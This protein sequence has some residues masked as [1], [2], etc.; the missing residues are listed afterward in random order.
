MRKFTAVVLI[1]VLVCGLFGCAGKTPDQ[2]NGPDY[3]L[4][5]LLVYK[6]SE[7]ARQIGMQ[8]D[9]G[10]MTAMEF[11]EE[12]VSEAATFQQAVTAEPISA[13]VQTDVPKTIALDITNMCSRFAGITKLAC[14]GALTMSDQIY[15][16]HKLVTPA[17]VYLRYSESCQFVV[18]FTPLGNNLASVWAYPLYP[19]VT[20]EVL[21][22]YFINDKQLNAEQIRTACR[23]GAN[24]SFQAQCTDQKTSPKYYSQLATTVLKE[25]KPLE[26]SAVSDYTTD[27]K[28]ISNVVSLSHSMVSGI[29]SVQVFQFPAKLERQV[30]EI[31]SST[32]YSQQLEAY[33]RQLVYLT[34]PRQLSNRY[35]E[36]WMVTSSLLLATMETGSMGAI[37]T[38]DEVP[39]LVLIQLKGDSCLLMSVYPS[40][41]N[42]YLY[43][44]AVLPQTFQEVSNLLVNMGATTLQ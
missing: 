36:D 28:I 10:Y 44:Y 2:S 9:Q 32:K 23:A 38:K 20:G 25:A 21:Q 29:Q 17:A 43:Q 35:G 13:K 22:T 26:P 33:T 19:E 11:P 5:D 41:H 42:I 7:I 24:G 37:A 15:I 1:L 3:S 31:L 40:Q 4:P 39:V 14:C 12:V 34:F 6:A 27:A 16:S 30:E 8:A 18:V